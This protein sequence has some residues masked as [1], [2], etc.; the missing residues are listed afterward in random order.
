MGFVKGNEM[1]ERV[2]HMREIKRI[3]HA[4]MQEI[5]YTRVPLGQAFARIADRCTGSFQKWLLHMSGAL[6]ERKRG[7]MEQIWHHCVY[8]H[9]NRTRLS[10]GELELLARQGAYMGQ[11]DV[12]MQVAAIGLFLEQWEERILL[13]TKQLES[14]RRLARS[15]GVLG[16]VFLVILLL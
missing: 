6:E 2:K 10:G 5:Q 11:L 12:T 8:Q 15:I 14:K 9:L 16:G 7:S 3:F 1:A 4:L 13:A